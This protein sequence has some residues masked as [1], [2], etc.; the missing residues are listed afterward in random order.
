METLEYL[1]R[2][3]DPFDVLKVWHQDIHK[4]DMIEPTAVTLITSNKKGIPSARIVLLKD[5]SKSGLTFYTNYQSHKSKD[6][7]ENSHVALLIYS[8][9]LQRQ[10]RVQGQAAK[11][12][13]EESDTYFASRPYESQI[14]A[15]ASKQSQDILDRDKLEA[16][17]KNF[18]KKY[19]KN[20]PRP[21]HWGGF[22]IHPYYFEFWV[23]GKYRLHHRIVFVLDR[24]IKD[25]KPDLN[26]FQAQ[27]VWQKKI[28]SP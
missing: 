7:Q 13:P 9:R 22:R 15:W 26:M 2:S 6:I 24:K 5:I 19:P 4:L 16:Q 18:Q 27:T 25:K 28:L 14:G 8:D 3:S 1:Y 12:S 17:I 11:I 23:A 10:V 20:V 21:P